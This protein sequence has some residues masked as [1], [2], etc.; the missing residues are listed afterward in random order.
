MRRIVR[1]LSLGRLLRFA[2]ALSLFMVALVPIVYA[3]SESAR[4]SIEVAC[5]LICAVA[6]ALSYYDKIGHFY[7]AHISLAMLRDD[8]RL[9]AYGYLAGL[10]AATFGGVVRDIWLLERDTYLCSRLEPWFVVL[11]GWSV[12]LICALNVPNV[13]P[14]GQYI[15]HGLDDTDGLALGVFAVLGMELAI[16]SRQFTSLDTLV[17]R[18]YWVLAVSAATTVGGGVARDVM[19]YLPPLQ[20]ASWDRQ[21]I[22]YLMLGPLAGFVAYMSYFFIGTA[23]VASVNV[24]SNAGIVSVFDLPAHAREVIVLLLYAIVGLGMAVTWLAARELLRD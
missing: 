2:A 23:Y 11:I 14:K 7:R 21:R 20:A 13:T 3:M 8:P 12:G 17:D 15:R 1:L 19:L 5:L 24:W 18:V 9:L 10:T 6:G 4:N 16:G 22:V